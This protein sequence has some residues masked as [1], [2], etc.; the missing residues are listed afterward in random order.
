M[1]ASLNRATIPGDCRSW[2]ICF[3]ALICF[4]VWSSPGADTDSARKQFLSGS[5]AG[6]IQTCEQ[7]IRDKEYSEEWRLL[8]IQSCLAVGRYADA[9]TALTNALSRYSDSV[10][11]RLLGCAVFPYAGQPDRVPLLLDEVYNLARTRTWA[12]RSAPD[13]VALGQ[14][15]LL[16]GA[17]PRRVLDEFFERVKR[18]DP[19]NREA[20]LASGQLA[21]DKGDFEL[22]AKVF[23]EGLKRLADDADLHFGLARAYA[24]SDRR[25]ML[26]SLEEALSHNTNHVPS[27]LLLA[28][29]AVDSEQYDAAEEI[30]DRVSTVNPWQPEAW[31][32]QSVLAHLRSDDK[33]E[34]RSRERA[35]W[36]WEAN[37]RVDHLIGRKLSQKYHFAEGAAHQRE[38]LHF[39][40]D[41]LPAG[42]QLAQDLLRL[43]DETEGW[44]LA[45]AVHKKD[46]Y[47]VTAYNL[48]TLHESLNKFQTLSNRDFIVRM[49]PHEAAVYGERAMALLQRARTH[50]LARYG[51]ALAQPTIVEIF[52]DQKDF[53]VRTF[54][55]PENDGYLGVCFGRVITA[56]S[57]ASHVAR[58]ANWE[59]VLWHEFTHVVTLQ[60]TRNKMPRWLSE[61]IS[62]YEERL[63]NPVWGQAMTP[64]YREMVLGK[65]LTPVSKLSG[66]FLTPKSGEHM[67]F[68][69]YES[70]LVVEFL[71]RKFGFASLQRV[72]RD[73][74][75]GEDINRAIEH[76]TA[77]MEAIEKDFAAFAR[78]RAA[79]LAPGL[80]WE[81]PLPGALAD[82]D[83]STDRP[84][85]RPR[86]LDVL[87]QGDAGGSFSDWLA[88]HPTN[89]WGLTAQ[90]K[91][92][93]DDKKW[94]EAKAPLKKLQDLYPGYS[95]SD[96][97]YLLLAVVHRNLNETELEREALARLAEINGENTEAFLRLMEL[98]AAAK[99]WPA[100]VLNAERFLAVNPLVSPPHRFLAR[101]SEE[102]N[103]PTQAVA[104]WQ[105]LLLLDPPDPAEVHFR[106][107]KLLHQAGDP[108]AR[109]HVLQALE[110]APRY[111]DAHRLL[112]EI[113]TQKSSN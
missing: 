69:Y 55:M 85:R 90:A 42:I 81:K 33:G 46:G 102:L 71:V 34:A 109:R 28:D 97:A 57:P 65:E 4:G 68:A 29:H 98:A 110:E 7:A 84:G 92:L 79:Q 8:L 37:P 62:V 94:A 75:G 10:R 70:S 12:Y 35:L 107:A 60:L 51:L 99:E 63:A 13:L 96:N 31:A 24:P 22:A 20:Y 54:G 18:A 76:H 88:K 105:T 3:T 74:A 77:P 67:Q 19:D 9:H 103:R 47:D 52:P 15:F 58:S 83:K 17:E 89:F 38:A 101:A 73:L 27:L 91:K 80:D 66:A 21:L 1:P 23:Q 61:G 100:V 44:H 6:C 93:I 59:A 104:G 25:Q 108:D 11:L 40:P 87:T 49:N 36:Y 106:L 113:S 78:E 48:V 26:A 5:Y 43:G 32:C 82:V 45:E 50:L 111:R 14:A 2:T 53:A 16:L 64:R 86:V 95:G 112:L 56:N 39:A 41:F 72:L 30:L